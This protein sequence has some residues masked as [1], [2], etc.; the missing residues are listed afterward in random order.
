MDAV[1]PLKPLEWDADALLAFEPV[2]AAS[3]FG[4]VKSAPEMLQGCGLFEFAHARQRALLAMRLDQFTGGRV[5]HIM[6]AVSLGADPLQSRFVMGAIEAVAREHGAAV[7]SLCT[8]H[9]AIAKSA[10]RWG[11]Q[12]TGAVIAKR[13]GALQ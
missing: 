12:I 2:A 6:G 7:L 5:M 8:E 10:H 1:A 11:G 9:A 4:A 3:P 13:L